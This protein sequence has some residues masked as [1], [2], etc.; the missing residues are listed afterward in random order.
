MRQEHHKAFQEKQKFNTEM[1]KDVFDITT[2]L[3]DSKGVKRTNRSNEPDES[4]PPPTS[5]SSSEKS[6]FL[7]QT[8]ASR[9]VVPPGFAGTILDKNLAAKSLNHPYVPVVTYLHSYCQNLTSS[10]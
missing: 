4:A 7:S 2:L 1:K 6:S 8:T 9:P 5:D 3:D 10:C